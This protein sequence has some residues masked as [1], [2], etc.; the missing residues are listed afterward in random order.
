[1]KGISASSAKASESFAREK[2]RRVS[3]MPRRRAIV[4]ILR[5]HVCKFRCGQRLF[6]RQI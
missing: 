6:R 3:V 2:V 5:W 4:L 1:M